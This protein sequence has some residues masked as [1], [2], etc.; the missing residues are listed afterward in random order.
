LD[1][2]KEIDKMSIKKLDY[3]CFIGTVLD[4]KIKKAIN[5]IDKISPEILNDK[6]KT[7][8]GAIVKAQFYFTLQTVK[9][10]LTDFKED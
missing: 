3:A 4:E 9:G 10:I 2:K 6:M 7:E 8:E 5:C 1:V